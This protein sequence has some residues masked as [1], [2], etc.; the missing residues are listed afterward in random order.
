MDVAGRLAQEFDLNRMVVERLE[1]Y[2]SLVERAPLNLTAW[3]GDMLWER[4]IM[5]SLVMGPRLGQA[6]GQ[7]LD[8][9]SGGGFPGMVLAI[10]YSESSW[11]LLDSRARRGDFLRET[12]SRLGLTNVHVVVDRAE[13]WIRREPTRR[14]SFDWVTLRAV[15]STAAS[16][17][18]GLPYVKRSGRMMLV[19]GPN[20]AEE[21][22]EHA[23]WLDRL[24]GRVVEWISGTVQNADGQWDQIAVIEKVSETPE[25]YPRHAKLLGG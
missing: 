22:R 24:G 18:L 25:I 3:R 4:G 6:R 16:L 1:Q 12:V 14:A 15:S 17:E 23:P 19:K 5:D 2:V 10:A 7:G 9:G 21:V 11:V 20:G 13:E 8:I